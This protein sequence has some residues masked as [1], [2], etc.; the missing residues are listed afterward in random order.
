MKKLMVIALALGT[1]GAC[2]KD[3]KKKSEPVKAAPDKPAGQDTPP[4]DKPTAPSP[5][6]AFPA[7]N[8]EID[9][10]HSVLLWR[11]KHLGIGYTYG[12]FRDFSGKYVV[13]ADPAKQSLEL[14]VKVDSIDSRDAK[15]DE[16]LK[17]PDFF[18]AA[19]FPTLTFKST[20]VE[21]AG[22]A[23]KVSGDLTMHGVTKPVTVDVTLVGS[24]ED[25][26]KNT[27]TGYEA[28]LVVNRMDFGIAYMPDG[29]SKDIDLTIA[30]EGIKK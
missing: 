7:G 24:G 26:W 10:G 18:N 23:L 13:D 1:V 20:K 16:H 19:Q 14:S 25:P 2:S 11:A 21:A 29:I 4:A 15:R 30:F 17:G 6:A 12:W 5:T 8:Y 28:K 27:R 22:A 9:A 3:T